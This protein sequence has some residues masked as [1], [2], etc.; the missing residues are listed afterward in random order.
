MTT[1]TNGAGRGKK[2]ISTTIPE[3]IMA[4]LKELADQS[5]MTIS[6]YLRKAITRTTLSRITF[7]TVET[8]GLN[9]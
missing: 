7:Q 4:Q 1:R 3:P 6:G 9:Q 5:G 2:H 8:T